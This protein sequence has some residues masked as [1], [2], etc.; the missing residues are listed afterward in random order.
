M[1]RRACA[2]CGADISH[3]HVLA[4][5]CVTCNGR[6]NRDASRRALREHSQPSKQPVIVRPGAPGSLFP[7]ADG[8]RAEIRLD[9]KKRKRVFTAR[10]R[11]R[12]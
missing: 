11:G 2:D 7:I 9:G 12:L 5:T 10:A 6:R 8:Y 3:R 4:K 1:S